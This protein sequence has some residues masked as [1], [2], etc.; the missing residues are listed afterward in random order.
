MHTFD[1]IIIGSGPCSEPVLFHLSK[2]KLDCLIL[3]SGNLYE[4]NNL[5]K[6]NKGL[7]FK[8]QISPKQKLNQF[9]CFDRRWFHKINDFLFL[10]CKNFCY[11]YSFKSGGLSNSWGG[12]AFEW[13][14]QEIKKTTS[15]PIKQIFNSYKLIRER[16]FIKKR[17]SF[18]KM[19]SFGKLLLKYKFKKINFKPAKFFLDENY[20]N[21]NIDYPF[22]QNLIWN[23]RNSIKK[24]ITNAPN[25]NYKK[26]TTV[27]C[28][29]RKKDY[30]EICCKEKENIFFVKTKSII[31]CAGA[32]NSAFLAFSGANVDNVTLRFSHNHAFLIPIFC[33][34]KKFKSISKNYLEIPELSWKENKNTKIK[35]Y[36]ISSGYFVNSIFI[37][38]EL[39][40]NIFIKN[41]NFL[42]K[43]ISFL[44]SRFGLITIFIPSKFSRI[45]LKLKKIKK[46]DKGI[47]IYATIS[48][49]SNKKNL[50]IKKYQ[51]SK[52]ILKSLPKWIFLL[53]FLT[54]SVT[55]GGDI[56]YSATLPEDVANKSF[57]NTSS[58]GEIIKL[59]MIFAADPS[60][61]AYLSSLPHTFTA[62][63]IIEASMP[64]IIKK[65]SK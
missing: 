24:Y 1:S 6:K 58:I 60:R 14:S 36:E 59:P 22:N 30:W 52:I 61:L 34:R 33:I 46:V 35:N 49:E 31:L 9:K 48:N 16:L 57:F 64:Q 40:N 38:K 8:K 27:L 10:S 32:L 12:G 39:I 4:K 26:N 47:E 5:L 55:P 13:S 20:K 56:H 28:F 11:L 53:K 18:S 50:K 15:I 17:N 7:K 21:K 62:M 19:T 44:L 51:I 65:I 2:T 3:D 45:F 23:S 43:I 42:Q 63:A 37:F 54:R 29:N 25:L 41:N